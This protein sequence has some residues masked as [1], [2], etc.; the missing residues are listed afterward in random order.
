MTKVYLLAPIA[1][2]LSAQVAPRD[3]TVEFENSLVRIV[4]VQYRPHQKTAMHDHPAT[5]TVYVY[6]TDGGRLRISHEGEEPVIRPAVRA[7]AIRFQHAV[8][9]RH[10]VEE[11]DGVASEYLRLELKAQPPDQPPTDVRRAPDDRTPYES[12]T[13]RIYRVTCA[14]H[15]TCPPSAH[16]EDPAVVVK[17]REFRWEPVYPLATPNYH[18]MGRSRTKGRQELKERVRCRKGPPRENRKGQIGLVPQIE[19]NS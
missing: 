13:L 8:A 14:A 5:P 9:E 16:P 10:V 4:R 1:A 6:V 7:G 18:G 17:G 11:I 15:S 2:L 19:T 12:P 3:A